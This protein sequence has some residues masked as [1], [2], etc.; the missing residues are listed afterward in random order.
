MVCHS[1]IYLDFDRKSTF[2]CGTCGS[3]NQ[4]FHDIVVKERLWRHLDFWQYKSF[5]HA[6][7]PR[8]K[9][10]KCEKQDLS[11]VKKVAIDETSS[12]RG[13]QYVSLVV[14]IEK[15]NVIYVIE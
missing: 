5:I 9:C 11:N 7:L 4:P 3:K 1:F 14:D 12:K 15:R 10:G 13:H 6:P 8:V 2:T